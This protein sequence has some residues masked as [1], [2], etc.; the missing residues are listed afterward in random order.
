MQNAYNTFRDVIIIIETGYSS[1][2]VSKVEQTIP[3]KPVIILF[4][5]S[6]ICTKGYRHFFK[7]SAEH[8]ISLEETC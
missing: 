6:N 5:Q 3:I 1:K 2:V 8:T 7:D 4:S